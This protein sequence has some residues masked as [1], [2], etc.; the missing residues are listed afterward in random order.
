MGI[1]RARGSVAVAT[2]MFVALAA[3]AP[4]GRDAGA[5][6]TDTTDAAASVTTETTAPA[7]EAV[8]FV[9]VVDG[10]TVETSAG[11]VRIIGIDAPERGQCGESEASAALS[12]V[13]APGDPVTLDLPPGQNDRDD[14]GRLLRYVV[15]AAGVDLG[16]LQ[17][18]AGNAVARYDSTDGYPAH[19]RE[20]EYRSAQIAS[21]DPAGSVITPACRTAAAPAAPPATTAKETGSRANDHM[22][23]RSVTQR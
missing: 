8:A 18:H 22:S 20:A 21:L 19:P 14:Y 15:T 6:G 11:T 17:V 1:A 2:A 3:C 16:T 7:A 9:A 4:A 10:D 12:R 5:R 23:T 13:L